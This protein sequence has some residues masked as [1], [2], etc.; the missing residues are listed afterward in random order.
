MNQTI[1]DSIKRRVWWCLGVGITGW[2]LI[3]LGGAVARTLPDSIPAGAI[4]SA[5]IAVFAVAMLVMQRIVKCPKCKAKLGRTIAM[6]LAFNWGSG[7]RISFCPY[8]G[9]NLDEPLP[10]A[11]RPSQSFN[12]LNPIK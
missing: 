1:R 12:P 11:Q 2:I 10:H 6:P 4:S 5:G 7:P 8:C 9:V 3:P